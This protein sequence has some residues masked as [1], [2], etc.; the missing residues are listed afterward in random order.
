MSCATCHDPAHAYGPPNDLAVQLGG[1]KGTLQGSRAVPSLRYK[2]YTPAY[3]DLLD[4]PDGMSAPGP[5]GGFAWDGRAATLAAQARL[6]LLSPVEMA[7]D[8]PEDVARK[9]RAAPYA[10]DL[11][12]AF[13]NPA[14]I[15][16]SVLFDEVL[17]ALQSFQLEDSSFHPYDSK[18]DLHA[19]NKI[20]GQFTAAEAR[21][22][23]VFADPAAGNCASC[24]FP[25]AGIG[26]SSG[27]FTDFSYAA[28]GVPRNPAIGENR[29]PT[30]FDM[31]L[32][33][34]L[35][36]DHPD[37]VSGENRFCGLFK[38]PTLR[39]VTLRHVFFHNGVIHSL[40]QALRFYA[41]R[42]TRPELWYPTVGGKVVKFDDLP[43]AYGRNI[44]PQLPLDGRA[45]GSKP[46]LSEQNI[47][48]LLCFLET[49]NDG[50]VPPVAPPRSGRCVN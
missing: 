31:G 46:P 23:R 19:G 5:G 24:H 6:P 8:G 34:P 17:A 15:D 13:G 41:T 37:G 30:H 43:A 14:T 28:I 11:D 16:D 49:L 10:R 36:S 7:N 39:N 42:D 12:L 18:F 22:F 33:G 44:D 2:E 21:G 45:R 29:D 50:Y 26:G 40:D 48:D 38:T 3:A 32:C 20:G 4:N 27:L 1:K 35:R 9:V 25:G 47:Q